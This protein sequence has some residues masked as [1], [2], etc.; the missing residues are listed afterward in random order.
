MTL[1]GSTWA[2]NVPTNQD[3]YSTKRHD[4]TDVSV[5]LVAH[6]H[7]T[8]HGK[9]ES[10]DSVRRGE[11]RLKFSASAFKPILLG[12]GWTKKAKLGLKKIENSILFQMRPSSA[13]FVY[14]TL[15]Q[16]QAELRVWRKC[17]KVESFWGW[18]FRGLYGT[19]YC[20]F[21]TIWKYFYFLPRKN[22]YIS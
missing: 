14:C 5:Q 22:F 20:R 1:D 19:S 12:I 3:Y 17:E 21:L 11:S 4:S 15:C 7:R 13:F 18:N 6:M 8:V 2:Q 10:F 16:V 9:V